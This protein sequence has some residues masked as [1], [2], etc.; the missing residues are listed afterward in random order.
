MHSD[1]DRDVVEA[2]ETCDYALLHMKKRNKEAEKSF[3]A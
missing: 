3:I 1:I 2:A